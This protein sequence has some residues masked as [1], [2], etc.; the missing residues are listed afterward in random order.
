MVRIEAFWCRGQADCWG[1]G[2]RRAPITYED[3]QYEQM[4]G[5]LATDTRMQLDVGPV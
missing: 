5:Y 3:G 2:T 1:G 4:R